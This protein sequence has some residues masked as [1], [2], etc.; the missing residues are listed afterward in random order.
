MKDY[1]QKKGI[2]QRKEEREKDT[3]WSPFE[4]T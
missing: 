1:S 4:E 3:D 2:L